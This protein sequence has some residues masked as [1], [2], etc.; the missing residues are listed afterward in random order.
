MYKTLLAGRQKWNPRCRWA[1]NIEL[2]HREIGYED[3]NWIEPSQ[4]LAKWLI[5]EKKSRRAFGSLK[6]RACLD[7]RRK[8]GLESYT[9]QAA[10]ALLF[11][12]D[13]SRSEIRDRKQRTDI[14]TYSFVNR[15]IKNRNQLPAE[16]LGTFNCKPKIF[17]KELGKQ[18]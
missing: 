9:R 16:A 1:N 11:E 14:G 4:D 2:S 5:F 13:W 18:L 17:R 10:K 15:T 8:T 12:Q 7:R 3:E 6:I